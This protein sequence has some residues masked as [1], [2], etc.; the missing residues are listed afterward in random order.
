[1]DIKLFELDLSLVLCPTGEPLSV[2]VCLDQHELFNGCLSGKTTIKSKLAVPAQD[3]VLTIQLNNE[4][5]DSELNI[6]SITFNGIC[7]QQFIWEGAYTPIYPEPWA[8]EQRIA[9]KILLPV[10]YHCGQLGWSGVWKL[11]FASPIFTWIHQVEK[12]GW[13]YD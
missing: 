9:G 12:L 7:S 4:S 11:K 6:D 2:T 13:L 3:H 8:T 1:M 10:L 5:N